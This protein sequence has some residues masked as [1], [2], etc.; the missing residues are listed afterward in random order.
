MGD[1]AWD[2]KAGRVIEIPGDEATLAIGLA[3]GDYDSSGVL[4]GRYMCRACCQDLILRA[5][6]PGA[7][8]VPHFRHESS[9]ECPA[10][11]ERQREIALDDQVVIDLRD[12]LLHAWPGATVCLNLPEDP[13][14]QEP[15]RVSPG[16]MPPAIVVSGPD[17]PVVIERPRKLPDPEAVQR[18]LLA[19]HARYGSGARH[20]WFLAKDPL[21]FAKC[22]KIRVA[23]R[24]RGRD[25]HVTVA[26]T[27]QQLAI[28]AAGGGVYWLDGQQ[29]LVP[30][31]V[32][33]FIHAPRDKED[34]NFTDWRRGHWH[35]DWRISHPLPAP[36]ATR[37]GLA[38]LSL[39]QMTSTKASF[40][41]NEARDLMQRLEDVQRAR[42]RR[43]RADARELYATNNPLPTPAVVDAPGQ[44]TPPAPPEQ[45][46]AVPEPP[47]ASDPA[48]GQVPDESSDQ[49]D[50]PGASAAP[51]DRTGSA[52]MSEPPSPPPVP[53]S[54][55]PAA[56]PPSAVPAP[57]PYPPTTPPAPLP[58]QRPRGLR[59]ML[60][61]LLGSW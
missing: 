26:P 20:V 27:E 13:G 6:K 53:P 8:Q 55:P 19:V 1:T 47:A 21:Q 43:R 48:G 23:P 59:G 32:H 61:R 5:I 4:R 22:G 36:D 52:P 57:P 51:P 18:R 40:S 35:T 49:S 54:A 10:S 45:Q 2:R 25:D 16:W 31:G 39:H 3:R 12:R 56:P 37:W 28:I 38:P 42:W 14:R 24:D 9:R 34:W 33:D 30:Y 11:A 58:E 29:V 44:L 17:G 41:L 7:K 60:R 50:S 15:G 46:D